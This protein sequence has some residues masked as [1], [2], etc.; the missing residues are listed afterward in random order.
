MS[1]PTVDIRGLDKE[2]L[3]I[4]LLG[5]AKVAGFFGFHGQPSPPQPTEIPDKKVLDSYIDYYMG[6]VI[7]A[8]LSGD[9]VDPR[10]Y[11]RDNGQGAFKS[12]VDE[13][14]TGAPL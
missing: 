6:R 13:L 14:R 8:N 2:R 3:F 11:D 7:K 4:A 9:T 10:G 1:Y 12:V 5:G